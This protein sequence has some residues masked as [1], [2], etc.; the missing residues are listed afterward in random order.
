MHNCNRKKDLHFEVKIILRLRSGVLVFN[1]S[2]C[3]N[4]Y[5]GRTGHLYGQIDPIPGSVKGSEDRYIINLRY[6]I[7]FLQN[8]G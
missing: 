4:I 7:F 8:N 2:P 5:L 1:R 3:F 6:R